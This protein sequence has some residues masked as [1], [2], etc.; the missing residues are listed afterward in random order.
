E[1]RDGWAVARR[2]AYTR[3]GV[4]HLVVT[5]RDSPGPSKRDRTAEQAEEI[6]RRALARIEA[7]PS[8]WAQVVAETSDEPG[9]R[10]VGGYLGDFT[11]TAEARRRMAPEIE[12]ELLQMAPGARGKEVVVTRFGFH[13]FWRLD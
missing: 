9:S 3:A 5:H 2:Q 7:D 6:A 11:T 12:R 10:A 4:R 1:T 13:I 8:S